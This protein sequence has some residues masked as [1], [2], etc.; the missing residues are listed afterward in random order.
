MDLSRNIFD[1]LWAIE[2]YL[3]YRLSTEE[4]QR[5]NE[6]WKVIYYTSNMISPKHS[7]Y[8]HPYH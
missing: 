2:E 7:I 5:Y 4:Y 3:K 6:F 1:I 8:P